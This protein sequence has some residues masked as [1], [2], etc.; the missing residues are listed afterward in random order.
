MGQNGQSGGATPQGT[1]MY[2]RQGTTPTAAPGTPAAPAP[3]K[4]T[5]NYPY[6]TPQPQYGSSAGYTH[7]Q[8]PQDT[9]AGAYGPSRAYGKIF[10]LFPLFLSSSSSTSQAQALPQTFTHEECRT[11]ATTCYR[12]VS[13]C[14]VLFMLDRLTSPVAVF[15]FPVIQIRVF[16]LFLFFHFV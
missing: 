9:S 5:S 10:F 16:V 11:F 13:Y 2:G 15:M 6:S 4:P 14:I 8:P 7:T 1:D 12:V 3:Q